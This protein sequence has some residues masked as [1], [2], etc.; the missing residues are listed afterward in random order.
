MLLSATIYGVVGMNLLALALVLGRA[1]YFHTELYRPMLLNIGLSIAPVLV[2]G[3][4]LLPVLVMVSTG[5]PTVLIVSLVALVLL[6]WLLLLPNAGYLITELNLSHRRPGDGV[7]EWYDVLLVLTLAMSGVLNTV[8]N[9]FLVVLAWVVFRY[10]ALEPLQYAEARLA[11]AGVLL[12]VAFGIYLGRN[13]RL[14]S[15]D[16]RKPWRLVAKVWRH[17][18]VRANLGNAIGFTL[19]A[20]LF[21]GLMFLVVIG[22]IVSAV[23]ALSG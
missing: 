15:W 10:D 1:R 17:L 11:I 13:L 6:A 19:I 2:L 21:L 23:I 12:L 18:R 7:P 5:A 9:V 3:L 4:G 8:V 16:V 20:A 22:P 14:N